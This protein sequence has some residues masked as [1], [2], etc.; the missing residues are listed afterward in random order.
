MT[1]GVKVLPQM[2]RREV[3]LSPKFE[4]LFRLHASEVFSLRR[5]PS[6]M[7]TS[8]SLYF[9]LQILLKESKCS[10]EG[11]IQ[12]PWL[13]FPLLSTSWGMRSTRTTTATR[14][15]WPSFISRECLWRFPSVPPQVY[16]PISLDVLEAGSDKRRQARIRRGCFKVAGSPARITHKTALHRHELVVLPLLLQY[17]SI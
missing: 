6:S 16:L 9:F 10:C 13:H 17:P 12:M 15:V 7:V 11:L 3:V 14:P 5:N 1:S 8:V 4:A 2:E